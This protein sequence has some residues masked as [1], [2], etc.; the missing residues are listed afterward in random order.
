MLDGIK[1]SAQLDKGNVAFALGFITHIVTENIFHPMIYYFT[2]NYYA[3]DPH[4]RS[5][6]IASHRYLETFL[7]LFLIRSFRRKVEELDL[8]K[9]IFIPLPKRRPVFSFYAS[10]LSDVS[11][12][13]PETI[14]SG[15]DRAYPSLLFLNRLFSRKGFYYLLKL[16]NL[17]DH[18]RI[19]PYLQLFYP[20]GGNPLP[21]LF[22]SPFT[23]RNPVSGEEISTSMQDLNREAT[24]AGAESIID[25]Y[26]YLNDGTDDSFLHKIKIMEGEMRYFSSIQF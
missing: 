20:P 24:T 10:I 5:Q 8:G 9:I 12:D 3:S 19:S 7:D 4:R 13:S 14:R 26:R 11:G 21:S 1:S 16:F 23:Y 6:N 25:A 17:L 18:E 2:G 15:L 22:T